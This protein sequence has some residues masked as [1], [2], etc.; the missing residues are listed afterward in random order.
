MISEQEL[1]AYSLSPDLFAN[2]ENFF[3]KKIPQ[4]KGIRPVV[5]HNDL[6][7]GLL[8]KRAL[9]KRRAMWMISDGG[10]QCPI[11]NKLE[12]ASETYLLEKSVI[13]IKLLTYNRPESLLRCLLSLRNAEYFGNDVPLDI[14]IDYDQNSNSFPTAVMQISDE[15][16]WPHG[17]KRVYYRNIHVGITTQWIEA[18]FPALE[19][20]NSQKEF[21]FF[22]EDDVEVSQFYYRWLIE[23]VKTYYLSSKHDSRLLFGISLQNIKNNPTNQFP[24]NFPTNQSLL[25][26]LPSTW[27]VLFSPNHWKT[28]RIWYEL[29]VRRNQ[30]ILTSSNMTLEQGIQDVH[31]RDQLY[32]IIK[33]NHP[34][35][36]LYISSNGQYF[37]S[38]LIRF[39]LETK[40]YFLY[41]HLPNYAL[42]INHQEPGE[43]QK[44]AVGPNSKLLKYEHE[45]SHNSRSLYSMAPLSALPIADFCGKTTSHEAIEQTNENQIIC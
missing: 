13:T 39:T 30:N 31:V 42:I 40:S 9:F 16:F 44:E 14:F 27:G 4:Q 24:Q 33:G 23:A 12:T 37:L 25:Y 41:P 45:I 6:M 17:E 36:R 7:E 21:A 28:F 2:G 5:V 1:S 34:A 32:P 26:Q 35:N 29:Q 38:W 43:F 3:R 18:W 11:P 20:T 8:G 10:D 19:T 22:V 15:F